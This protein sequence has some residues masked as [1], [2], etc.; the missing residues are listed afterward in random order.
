MPRVPDASSVTR[1]R[2]A[3]PSLATAL[4]ASTQAQGLFPSRSVLATSVVS[5]YINPRHR[6]YITGPAAA[7][8]APPPLPRITIDCG[9][10]NF[11]NVAN[12][13][14]TYQFE[15][16]GGLAPAST[17]EAVLVN[18]VNP[19]YIGAVEIDDLS[20]RSI[21]NGVTITVSPTWTSTTFLP[22]DNYVILYRLGTTPAFPT[23]AVITF[24][25][26]PVLDNLAIYIESVYR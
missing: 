16:V 17:F 5:P 10:T 1:F 18:V 26:L 3:N 4:R 8:P 13:T 19:S 14:V 20:N 12:P 24:G 21:M 22:Q 11:N 7:P 2:A 25:N 6:G 23:N 15:N 9:G